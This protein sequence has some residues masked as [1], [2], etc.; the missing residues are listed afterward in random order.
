M[1]RAAACDAKKTL[2]TVA[3]KVLSYSSSVTSSAS[4]VPVQLALLTRMS[5]RPKRSTVLSMRARQSAT[6]FT[7]V[8]NDQGASTERF[9]LFL[10]L[11]DLFHSRARIFCQHEMGACLRQS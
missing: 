11:L 1:T 4:P 6:L 7:S 3:S 2:F 9:D 8:G 5:T 10:Q